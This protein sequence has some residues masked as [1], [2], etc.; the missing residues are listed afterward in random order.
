MSMLK[1]KNEKGEWI[2]IPG[3]KGDKGDKGEPGKDAVTD[4]SYNPESENAQ[5]GK[6]VAEALSKYV[7][8]VKKVTFEIEEDVT[9]QL[10][11]TIGNFTDNNVS[12]E[13]SFFNPQ[14]IY[15]GANIC[16]PMTKDYA[17]YPSSPQNESAAGKW[18]IYKGNSTVEERDDGYL[19]YS[20]K[21]TKNSW[22]YVRYKQDK[23]L[24]AGIYELSIEFL[25][26]IE[27]LPTMNVQ[28]LNAKKVIS[29]NYPKYISD[30]GVKY[31]KYREES[32][33]F[34]LE[35]G[36]IYLFSVK[37]ENTPS[38]SVSIE[39]KKGNKVVGI[40]NNELRYL[41]SGI[42]VC[43][44]R[45]T[46]MGSTGELSLLNLDAFVSDKWDWTDGP[47]YLETYD[48]DGIDIWKL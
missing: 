7:P 29:T 24:M 38:N 42:V 19:Q 31:Y 15:K 5:S 6:A 33:R 48:L 39:D 47:Y 10:V 17:V 36:H 18:N 13:L 26:E 40:A 4:Q 25:G 8:K 27:Q 1:I 22:N 23:T 16:N 43:A 3:I 37:D 21:P 12:A 46:C 44:D 20:F 14:L 9:D 2:K 28:L 34:E 41:K 45:C 30:T 35:K 32:I 11:I